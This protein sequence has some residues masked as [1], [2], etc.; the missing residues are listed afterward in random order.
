VR[1]V[2]RMLARLRLESI[3][4]VSIGGYDTKMSRVIDGIEIYEPFRLSSLKGVWRWWMRAYVAGVAYDNGFN[5]EELK[6]IVR[7]KVNELLGSTEN[8]SK[9]GLKPLGLEKL[10][11]Y[12]TNLGYVKN[13]PRL[14]L[15]YIEQLTVLEHLEKRR[16]NKAKKKLNE[17]LG[18]KKEQLYEDVLKVLNLHKIS[19]PAVMN[20]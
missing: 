20:K 3:G 14:R 16:L 19:Y 4:P 11:D 17:L 12:Y 18:K 5:G 6:K 1:K 8:A 2:P 13:I 9:F 10:K 7:D 15:L